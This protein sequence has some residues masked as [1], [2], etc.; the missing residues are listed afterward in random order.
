M[1]RAALTAAEREEVRRRIQARVDL[2]PEPYPISVAD[3]LLPPAC[4]ADFDDA[5]SLDGMIVVYD[6]VDG[7]HAYAQHLWGSRQ[8]IPKLAKAAFE[9]EVA[10]G[11]GALGLRFGVLAFPSADREF[12][13]SVVPDSTIWRGAG[14]AATWE[15]VP[16]QALT[17]LR[18]VRL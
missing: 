11:R 9:Y 18:Q 7:L 8:T 14:D 3:G 1:F 5:A 13:F 10:Q 6:D 17:R 15:I 4:I 16:A 2:L 12:I